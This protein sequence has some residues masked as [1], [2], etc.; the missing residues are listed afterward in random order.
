MSEQGAGNR[1]AAR[2]LGAAYDAELRA[3]VA[4]EYAT[5]V[6]EKMAGR[7]DGT[8]GPA[9]KIVEQIVAENEGKVS[10]KFVFKYFKELR[11]LPDHNK[12]SREEYSTYSAFKD[13]YLIWVNDPQFTLDAVKSL[14][15]TS[16]QTSTN[17]GRRHNFGNDLLAARFYFLVKFISCQP[18]F[19]QMTSKLLRSVMLSTAYASLMKET[20]QTQAILQKPSDLH[21]PTSDSV[22]RLPVDDFFHIL[23]TCLQSYLCSVKVKRRRIAAPILYSDKNAYGL[24]REYMDGGDFE[25]ILKRSRGRAA[26]ENTGNGEVVQNAL[27]LLDTRPYTE[28]TLEGTF[29]LTLREIKSLYSSPRSTLTPSQ[30]LKLRQLGEMTLVMVLLNDNDVSSARK[31]QSSAL[32][33]DDRS[34]L[35]SAGPKSFLEFIFT[36]PLSPQN[37][38]TAPDDRPDYPFIAFVLQIHRRLYKLGFEVH[39]KGRGATLTINQVSDKY[40]EYLKKRNGTPDERQSGQYGLSSASKY[41]MQVADLYLEKEV[42]LKKSTAKFTEQNIPRLQNATDRHLKIMRFVDANRASFLD[43]FSLVTGETKSYAWGLEGKPAVVERPETQESTT[44]VFSIMT[45][46][47]VK[48]REMK[49]MFARILPPIPARIANIIEGIDVTTTKLM[50]QQGMRDDDNELKR[51]WAAHACMTLQ[52]HVSL[53]E[54]GADARDSHFDYMFS[55]SPVVGD[56]LFLLRRR[57]DWLAP[58]SVPAK[59]KRLFFCNIVYD[60]FSNRRG[61]TWKDKYNSLLQEIDAY[62]DDLVEL[63][64]HSIMSPQTIRTFDN[65][66]LFVQELKLPRNVDRADINPIPEPEVQR[67]SQGT[68][69]RI[70]VNEEGLYSL[71]ELLQRG[72]LK[73]KHLD[74]AF[75][76]GLLFRLALYDYEMSKVVW[77]HNTVQTFRGPEPNVRWKDWIKTPPTATYDPTQFGYQYYDDTENRINNMT[78]FCFSD[79]VVM[80]CATQLNEDGDWSETGNLKQ[81]VIADKRIVMRPRNTNVFDMDYLGPSVEDEK[82]ACAKLLFECFPQHKDQ[83]VNSSTPLVLK[84]YP[85]DI[86]RNIRKMLNTDDKD[87]SSAVYNSLSWYG[88]LAFIYATLY[89]VDLEST[90]G[91][92]MRFQGSETTFKFQ[93]LG[94]VSAGTNVLEGLFSDKYIEKHQAGALNTLVELRQNTPRVWEESV[95]MIRKIICMKAFNTAAYIAAVFSGV[96]FPVDEKLGDPFAAYSNLAS[97]D[98]NKEYTR[99]IGVQENKRLGFDFLLEPVTV[100]MIAAKKVM[101]FLGISMNANRAPIAKIMI[102]VILWRVIHVFNPST[103]LCQ[104]KINEFES[105]GRDAELKR[106]LTSTPH[107]QADL[108]LYTKRIGESFITTGTYDSILGD[109]NGAFQKALLNINYERDLTACE[110]NTYERVLN[111]V[112]PLVLKNIENLARHVREVNDKSVDDIRTKEEYESLS[113]NIFR[114]GDRY[115]VLMRF[116]DGDYNDA[117]TELQ[118]Q[119][120]DD[121]MIDLTQ[122]SQ[123]RLRQRRQ[124]ATAQL[125]KVADYEQC[126]NREGRITLSEEEEDILRRRLLRELNPKLGPKKV[127]RATCVDDLQGKELINLRHIPVTIFVEDG[128]LQINKMFGE[129]AGVSLQQIMMSYAGKVK[130]D[131]SNND[132]DDLPI[133]EMR[134]RRLRLIE[135]RRRLE[136]EGDIPVGEIGNASQMMYNR[137]IQRDENFGEWSTEVLDVFDKHASYFGSGFLVSYRALPISNVRQANML[138]DFSQ[139]PDLQLTSWVTY[140]RIDAQD[141][142]SIYGEGKVDN[143]KKSARTFDE[144]PKRPQAT[145]QEIEVKYGI[146][147]SKDKDSGAKAFKTNKY[148]MREFVLALPDN[149][150]VDF[151]TIDR[152][153]GN[154]KQKKEKGKKTVDEEVT[155]DKVI[156]EFSRRCRKTIIMDNS[157]LHWKVGVGRISDARKFCSE[158]NPPADE[159]F[160]DSELS[161]LSGDLKSKFIDT[162][163]RELPN[164]GYTTTRE[165][166]K[167]LVK[168][169]YDVRVRKSLSKEGKTP[170]EKGMVTKEDFRKA[171]VVLPSIIFN[172]A[173]SPRLNAIELAFNVIKHYVKLYITRIPRARK[174][175]TS[176]IIHAMYYHLTDKAI[177]NFIHC[178]GYGTFTRPVTIPSS[179]KSLMRQGTAMQCVGLRGDTWESIA[180]RHGITSAEL[181][182]F[183]QELVKGISPGDIIHVPLKDSSPFVLSEGNFG[184]D[185]DSNWRTAERMV[186]DFLRVN[187]CAGTTAQELKN[188]NTTVSGQPIELRRGTQ[189]IVPLRSLGGYKAYTLPDQGAPGDKTFEN[190]FGYSKI[191]LPEKNDVICVREQE[192]NGAKLVK[193]MGLE[194]SGGKYPVK[195]LD[196]NR[197]PQGSKLRLVGKDRVPEWEFADE[198]NIIWINRLE[199]DEKKRYLNL[200]FGETSN[201]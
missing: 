134:R 132:F 117:G 65:K 41:C 96:Y 17:L 186:N 176:G 131:S 196:S 118:E 44:K 75:F 159:V 86:E 201:T 110:G 195:Y 16:T 40:D 124:R 26:G 177:S 175:L 133:A 21:I 14:F 143:L 165:N 62:T 164:L 30:K 182:T 12:P 146:S 138:R 198:L 84:R 145:R 136:T 4:F 120:T 39:P 51:V 137:I 49:R 15:S 25:D 55:E 97:E 18:G 20:P 119:Y 94:N 180:R 181:K 141:R 128:D 34:S 150:I 95:D 77:T 60:I 125:N 171:N 161:E 114:V 35:F 32:S 169:M 122:L 2:T 172:P 58:P 57:R 129:R 158:K 148:L 112:D 188:I 67:N 89:A 56:L 92:G 185:A 113:R 19:S 174:N 101:S 173:Y 42:T 90:Q 91:V 160:V 87:V 6:G 109:T 140:L 43:E 178:A 52:D 179:W 107:G 38:T 47:S 192:G 8:R 68:I 130:D 103:T 121:F 98:T 191:R 105:W 111:D 45:N 83:K 190:S 157:K 36:T 11:K 115:K 64:R 71:K 166:A 106:Y 168:L 28:V 72:E 184:D 93:W 27:S 104:T 193:V 197:N 31:F 76:N 3:K 37:E 99:E 82:T 200:M 73:Y 48:R 123:H 88:T 74:V 63:F 199:Q 167:E 126:K 100:N 194:D 170:E 151:D 187:R 7:N 162:I 149:H 81:P 78:A 10:P 155:I 70:T 54:K 102:S 108:N 22:A 53:Q 69:T 147:V 5:R 139:R 116:S 24:A 9:R 13:A 80:G 152:E 163:T 142:L 1:G 66:L 144:F 46:A 154:K 183:N 23:W 33:E 85:I 156:S 153:A 135:E 50:S 79:S 29:P 61:R 127:F 189:I 59:S